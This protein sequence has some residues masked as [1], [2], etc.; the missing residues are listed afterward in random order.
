MTLA[1]LDQQYPYFTGFYTLNKLAGKMVCRFMPSLPA[2]TIAIVFI[3]LHV[4]AK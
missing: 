4:D 2:P 1:S 3:E